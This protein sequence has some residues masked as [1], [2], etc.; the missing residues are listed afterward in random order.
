MKKIKL[1]DYIFLNKD[2][3]RH[4]GLVN[5][6]DILNK[7]GYDSSIINFNYSFF[8][9]KNI[10]HSDFLSMANYVLADKPNFIGLSTL[11]DTFH[12]TLE[13]AKQ[14]KKISKDIVIFLGGPHSSLTFDYILK[15][16]DFIDFIIVGESENTIINILKNYSNFNDTIEGV[17][18]LKNK[19][20]HYKKS[21]QIIDFKN[22][23]VFDN[24]LSKNTTKI[25]LEGGRGCPFNCSFC[26]T[27]LHWNQ[28]FRLKSSDLL[29]KEIEFYYNNFNIKEFNI[30]HDL[31]IY[32]KDLFLEFCN[33]IIGKGL[34]KKISWSCSSRID[35]LDENTINLLS[36]AGCSTIFL[37]IESVSPTIQKKINKNIS[38]DKIF[39]NLQLLN[40]YNIGMFVS[41]IYGFPFESFEDFKKNIDFSYFIS[42]QYNAK[43]SMGK[44]RFYPGAELTLEY[45]DDLHFDNL[46]YKNSIF[47]SELVKKDILSHK[48]IFSEFYTI[49]TLVTKDFYYFDIFHNIVILFLKTFFK[50]TYNSLFKNGN[51]Y[52]KN[53]KLF[54]PYL[55]KIEELK[56]NFITF[57]TLQLIIE[58]Q[59]I[60]LSFI[61]LNYLDLLPLFTIECKKYNEIE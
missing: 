6:N 28:Q 44:L 29:V 48:L 60:F 10:E 33:L 42:A 24:L 7:N 52:Y 5:I 36:I 41:L 57:S 18:F 8:N 40:K 15:H 43:V 46:F 19:N 4:L 53:Y 22:F 55:S 16:Y 27:K 20:I 23:Q 51:D 12:I 35:L 25:S 54:I 56:K 26:C 14:L 1:I 11:C 50:Q 21:S 17:A 34:N 61:Q 39:T 2:S 30:E 37:G 3:N 47:K 32:S 59:N 31:F 49:T 45:L 13:L 58:F 38:I 9:K